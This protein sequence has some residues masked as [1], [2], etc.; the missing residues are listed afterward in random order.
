MQNHCQQFC[1]CLYKV[2]FLCLRCRKV[3]KLFGF[4]PPHPSSFTFVIL[5][6]SQCIFLCVYMSCCPWLVKYLFFILILI[7]TQLQYNQ[8]KKK[9]TAYLRQVLHIKKEK[10]VKI[11][12]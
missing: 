5:L 12:N 10:S 2:N 6:Q 3:G 8:T 1:F 4:N 11:V 7:V 9:T